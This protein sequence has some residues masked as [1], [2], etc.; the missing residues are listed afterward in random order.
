MNDTVSEDIP[1]RTK[2]LIAG[3][4]RLTP[5]RIALLLALITLAVFLPVSGYDFVN[6]DDEHYI[7]LHPTVLQGI[8]LG[9]IAE[10]ST[11]THH[12]NWHP[13]TSL[14]HMLDVELFGLNAG[15]HHSVNL[16]LHLA[17]TL[18]LFF[19]LSRTTGAAYCSAFVAALF[20]VHPLH[21]ESVAWISERKDVLSTTF[22]LLATY[23][24]IRYTE[25]PAWHRYL[26]VAAFFALGLMAKP[27]VVTLPFTLL[28][29]DFWPL[30]RLTNRDA[31]I[32]LIIEKLPLIC[33]SIIAC[34]ITYA[35]QLDAG[36][37][38]TFEEFP[39]VHR[40]GNAIVS[41]GLYLVNTL[42]PTNL[43]AFYPFPLGGPPL[44]KV[45]AAAFT[46]L[47]IS[48]FA[49]RSVRTKP[50]FLVG[51][52]WYL[53]TLVPVIGIV[54]VGAQAMADRY[55][56]V[57]L[58]GILVAATW[59]VAHQVEKRAWLQTTV[60]A[61]SISCLIAAVFLSALQVRYW[62]DSE[63][64]W[65]HAVSVTGE[66]YL[67]HQN[68]GV[69]I[70]ADSP[71]KAGEHFAEAL[72]IKPD[73]ADAHGN[74]GSLYWTQN[75]YDEALE[76]YRTAIA[77]DPSN[78]VF[79]G[80]LGLSLLRLQDTDG[81]IASLTTSV[82]LDP[83]QAQ[84]QQDLGDA[85]L[86]NQQPG[87]AIEHYSAALSLNPSSRDT[88]CNLAIAL[89]QLERFAD[90]RD[91]LNYVLVR[92]PEYIPAIHALGVAAA[93]QGDSDTARAAFAE[94]LR[95]DSTHAQARENLARLESA[96]GNATGDG[97]VESQP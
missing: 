88:L 68:L 59:L 57:P 62:R 84:P 52:L 75:R 8:T 18:L 66:N 26:V 73:Y 3:S 13:L 96:T 81:A 94:V 34:V 93:S 69:A 14:S 72:R 30:N 46:L 19:L 82:R 56:Y 31:A 43:A 7:T 27:M 97:S 10:M 50:Y 87:Q 71:T 78:A 70:V 6:Y 29:L 76:S 92:A 42:W 12:S 24:Y 67:A 89:I 48:V 77:L 25:R 32:R 61:V 41:Y 9:G 17:N 80:N 58:I 83:R 20:A 79:H 51:W 4:F 35:V 54:Q 16:L 5:L 37:V 63:S 47:G 45:I 64:L 95:L 53:G 1:D 11:G 36:A 2:E 49:L 33:L 22:W 91:E 39:L 86:K 44:W 21:V 38:K 85:L 90:A 15:A 28:L 23:A 60:I 55:T 74:M 65:T 40:L